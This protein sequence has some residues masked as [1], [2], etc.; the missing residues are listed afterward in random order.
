MLGPFEHKLVRAQVITQHPKE[1]HFRN[2]MIR[3]SGEHNRCPFVSEDT[4][5]SVGDHGTVIIAVRNWTSSENIILQNKTILG[6]AEPATFV[7]RPI[8]VDQTDRASITIVEQ[9]NKL[10]AVD[11]SDTSTEFISFAQN[12]LSSSEMSEEGLSEN[13]KRVSI[14]PQLVKPIPGPDLSSVFFFGGGEDAWHQL[15][16]VLNEYDDLFVKQKVI[17]RCTIAKHRIEQ[18]PEA[19]HHREG[20]MRMSPDKA[21]KTNLQVRNLLALGLIQ[22]SYSPWSSGIVMVKKKTGELRF[23]C[24]F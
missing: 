9:V 17:G 11:L 23:C 7:F 14:D 20:A 13:E 6:K 1:Y 19:I 16:N 4:L 24:D 12:L 18:E 15:A 3:P 8:A 10:Y 22:P 5:T 21:A 2:V